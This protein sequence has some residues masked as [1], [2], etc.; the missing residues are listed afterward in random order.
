MSETVKESNR[1]IFSIWAI[2]LLFVIGFILAFSFNSYEVFFGAEKNFTRLAVKRNST[3]VGPEQK[4]LNPFELSQEGDLNIQYSA[5]EKLLN[6]DDFKVFLQSTDDTPMGFRSALQRKIKLNKSEGSIMIVEF[7]S[8]LAALDFMYKLNCK[9][10]LDWGLES[11]DYLISISNRFLYFSP[12]HLY[13]SIQKHRYL[14]ER[15]AQ[16]LGMKLLNLRSINQSNSIR[17]V[18]FEWDGNKL[19]QGLELKIN[20]ETFHL[21][22]EFSSKKLDPKIY[23]R[24]NYSI[25]DLSLLKVKSSVSGSIFYAS[26]LEQHL[27]IYS[28][29]DAQLNL[30]EK[31]LLRKIFR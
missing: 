18:N 4:I 9:T 20:R 29:L 2:V 10:K 25:G 6:W 30:S 8:S 14:H 24:R 31:Y 3:V 28:D 26:Q 19:G 16:N 21:I 12:I 22:S 5:K 13:S 1:N 11:D 7:E 27:L 23:S 17:M 15:L